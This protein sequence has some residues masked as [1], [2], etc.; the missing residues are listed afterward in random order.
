MGSLG[1]IFGGG[2]PTPPPPKPVAEKPLPQIDDEELRRA[3]ER[4]MNR[5]RMGQANREN[6]KLTDERLGDTGAAATRSGLDST[7]LTG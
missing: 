4:E 2:K 6:N 7:I 3:K 1:S 5:L